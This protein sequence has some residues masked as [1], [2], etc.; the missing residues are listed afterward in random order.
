MKA[1]QGCGCARA[2]TGRKGKGEGDGRG[3]VAMGSGAPTAGAEIQEKKEEREKRAG[4]GERARVGPSRG[5][6]VDRELLSLRSPLDSALRI[7][8]SICISNPKKGFQNE[9]GQTLISNLDA[10]LQLLE[11]VLSSHH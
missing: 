5:S 6:V 3:A 8:I 10:V 11:S 7:T 2:E 9:I 1:E 4:G